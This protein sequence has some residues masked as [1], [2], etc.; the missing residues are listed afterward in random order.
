MHNCTWF[1]S[2]S[3]NLIS[4]GAKS[5]PYKILLLL[6]PEFRGNELIIIFSTLR[7]VPQVSPYPL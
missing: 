4:F 7:I 2:L 3:D 6:S 5:I 1:P